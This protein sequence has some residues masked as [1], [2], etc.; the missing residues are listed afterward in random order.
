MEDHPF[1]LHDLVHDL[2]I[3]IVVRDLAVSLAFYQHRL[4]F[5]LLD[6]QAHVAA[7]RCGTLRLYLFTHSPPTPDKP[8]ITLTN[9]NG[10][11]TTPVIIDLLVSDCQAAYERLQKR[12][13][14]FLTPPH[15]PRFA[16]QRLSSGI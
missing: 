9:L 5:T 6:Q 16:G 14:V 4:G 13:V 3:M 7:L 8:T 15:T 10:P 11:D 12:G 2:A 1:P